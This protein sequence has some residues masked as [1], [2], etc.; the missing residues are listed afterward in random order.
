MCGGSPL[1]VF[2]YSIV[3]GV[4][5]FHVGEITQERR[6]I[7]NSRSP[8]SDRILF[9]R[10][11]SVFRV[12]EITQGRTIIILSFSPLFFFLYYLIFCL[13]LIIQMTGRNTGEENYYQLSFSPL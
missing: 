9:I 3:F 11:L 12:G 10:L 7:I 6:N 1:T 5:D 2:N 8:L 13:F 4:I